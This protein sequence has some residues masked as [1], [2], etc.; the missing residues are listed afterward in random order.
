[1]TEPIGIITSRVTD[2]LLRQR[3]S[4][5]VDTPWGEAEVLTGTVADRPAV[6]VERYGPDLA[7][8]S[9]RVNFLANIWA[10]RTLGVRRLVSQ[11][12]IGSINPLLRPGDIVIAH[13]FLDRTKDRPRTFFDSDEHWVRVDMT[14]PFCPQMREV[15]IEAG[16][17]LSQRVIP[18][19][20]FACTEGP[21]FETPSEI[22]ALQRDGGDMVGT[23]LVPEVV[24][25][26]EAEICFAS[27]APIINYGAGLAPRVIHSGPDSMVDFYYTEGL[28]D[29]IEDIIAAAVAA[30]PEERTCACGVAL[31]DGFHGKKPSWLTDSSLD[32]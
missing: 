1:M 3:R 26:R 11:N 18:R 27:I 5:R 15:L 19:G 32:A 24:L 9:H 7:V 23:P 22:R 8:A 13:D 14:D 2:R 4:E 16:N 31:K 28:H 25:A 30:M 6:C 21:R 29:L 12:A 17:R 20:V 10:F